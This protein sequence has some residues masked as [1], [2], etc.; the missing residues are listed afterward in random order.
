MS[1]IHMVRKEGGSRVISITNVIPLDWRAV[2]L[3]LIKGTKTSITIK[4]ERIK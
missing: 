1:K 3:K 4:I 2:E